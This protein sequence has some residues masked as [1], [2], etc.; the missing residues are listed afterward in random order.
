LRLGNLSFDP[1]TRTVTICGAPIRLHRRE[2]ALLEALM[3]RANRVVS[4]ESLLDEVYGL[5]A[6]VQEHTLDTLVW[7]L[8]RR[9]K[10]LGPGV[11]IHLARGLGYMIMETTH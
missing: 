7:R 8:R 3:R 11:T 1:I 5:H 4:R 6:E 9:L 10:D 2:L